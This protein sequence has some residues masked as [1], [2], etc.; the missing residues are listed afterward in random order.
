[1]FNHENDSRL[2]WT[3]RRKL[4]IMSITL[5]KTKSEIIICDNFHFSK[6]DVR[7][8]QKKHCYRLAWNN[9]LLRDF[10]FGTTRISLRKVVR[11]GSYWL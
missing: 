4:S 10:S 6:D 9:G 3:T 8:R 2:N 7:L 11:F 5:T 1:M